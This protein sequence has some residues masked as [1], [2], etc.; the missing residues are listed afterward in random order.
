MILQKFKAL[1]PFRLKESLKKFY[2]YSILVP[3]FIYDAFRYAIFSGTRLSYQN[4][5]QVRA[6]LVKHYHVIEKG[7]SLKNPRP[8]FGASVVSRTIYFA[9]KYERSFGID[10]VFCFCFNA[11][12]E[13]KR[14][15]QLHGIENSEL[16]YFLDE[17]REKVSQSSVFEGGSKSVSKSAVLDSCGGNFEELALN[18]FSL[19]QFSAS[20][21]DPSIIEEAAR[22]AAKSP[23]VCNRPTTSII[24]FSQSEEKNMILK[25]QNG[26]RGFGDDA[27]H[28]ILILADLR[29]FN[30]SAERNQSFIDGGLTAMSFVYALQSKGIGTCF[31]NW[32]VN[33]GTDMKLKKKLGIPSH[34]NI[35]TAIAVGN[36]PDEFSVAQSPKLDLSEFYYAK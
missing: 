36:F 26:N 31:L 4:R 30:G 5:Y 9:K 2:E 12:C 27:S 23:C 34:Y 1:L 21:V 32:S 22:I 20:S 28:I 11:L 10:D 24:S 16:E 17:F 3:N 7:L 8:G 6:L 15:N 25:L 13:Y 19:R 14:F 29:S 33:F 35:I 18:R